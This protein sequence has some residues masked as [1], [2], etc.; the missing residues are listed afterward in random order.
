LSRIGKP[1][2]FKKAPKTPG[3]N[4]SSNK[5]LF[6]SDVLFVVKNPIEPVTPLSRFGNRQKERD[7]PLIEKI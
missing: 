4:I 1:K 3:K 2:I 6:I 5:C 7:L